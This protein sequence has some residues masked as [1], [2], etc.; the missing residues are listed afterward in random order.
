MIEIKNIN[1][2]VPCN[3]TAYICSNINPI[4]PAAYN[5]DNY[6]DIIMSDFRKLEELNENMSIS[7]SDTYVKIH[8]ASDDFG[9]NH[10]LTYP[11]DVEYDNEE[12][13]GYIT[14]DYLPKT[15]LQTISDGESIN[16]KYPAEISR[17]SCPWTK[18]NIILD[19]TL[20]FDQKRHPLKK[21]RG[22][23]HDVLAAM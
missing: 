3:V 8:F 18:R 1:T 17:R 19:M 2:S 14:F 20:T 6:R 9:D 4:R 15:F 21:N 12:W 5:S 16:I 10:N 7:E 22:N 23:F 13:S 11:F